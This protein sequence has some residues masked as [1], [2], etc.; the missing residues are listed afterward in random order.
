MSDIGIGLD[1]NNYYILLGSL[2]GILVL[3]YVF[4]AIFGKIRKKTHSDM[5]GNVPFME[6]AI[7]WRKSIFRV[8]R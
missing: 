1:P 4:I 7:Q 2:F 6:R 8:S 5:Y 3:F